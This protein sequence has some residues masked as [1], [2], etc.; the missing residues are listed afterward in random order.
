MKSITQLMSRLA[1]LFTIAWWANLFSRSQPMV[2]EVAPKKKRRSP[3]KQRQLNS[4]RK[5]TIADLL[6]SLEHSFKELKRADGKKTWTHSSVRKNLRDMGPVVPYGDWEL[7][8]DLTHPDK[9]PALAFAAIARE[10]G[11][12]ETFFAQFVYACKV[13][14]FSSGVLAKPH[15]VKYECGV[16]YTTA[17]EKK[18][19]KKED[20][21]RLQWFRY[22]I[23]VNRKSGEVTVCPQRRPRH[24]QLGRNSH[25]DGL[26][27]QE[28]CLPFGDPED[29][30]RTFFIGA[31]NLT[32]VKNENWTI[33]VRKDGQRMTFVIPDNQ[34]K[35]FFSNREKVYANSG[36]G[37]MRPIMHIVEGHQRKYASG[38]VADVPTH[39][40]GLRKFVWNGYDC[41]ISAPDFHPFQSQDF[42]GEAVAMR[43]NDRPTMKVSLV[44]NLGEILAEAEDNQT[45]MPSQAIMRVSQQPYA[46][47]TLH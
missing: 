24:Y 5:Q 29:K 7:P 8:L 19:D 33:S 1:K 15:D 41:S 27:R 18:D 16:C 45:P 37:R 25:K 6:G 32:A 4:E 9:L 36:S 23:T 21:L 12:K 38:K 22:D 31:L 34:A 10:H 20:K 40:R 26:V 46:P 42:A 35:V 2:A 28:W 39:I 47:P 14:R 30:I 43:D 11:D 17:D 3:K 44:E 13:D